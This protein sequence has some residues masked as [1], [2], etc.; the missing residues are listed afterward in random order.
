MQIE[1]ERIQM[2]PFVMHPRFFCLVLFSLVTHSVATGFT[3]AAESS[4][5]QASIV[6]SASIPQKIGRIQADKLIECS[7][8]DASV[9]DE[10][11]LWAINDGGDGPFIYALGTDGRDRGRLRIAG[12]VNR[13]WEG[14]ATF[15][16]N[17]R[18][19]ILVADF[20]DNKRQ[21]TKHT[22][23]V[24]EEPKLE[25]ERFSDNRVV[26][27]KWIVV[28]SYPDGKHD[29]EGI[30]VDTVAEKVFV[31][32]K[33]DDPP[34]LFALPLKP[35][36]GDTPVIAQKIA[37][38]ENIPPPTEVD[39]RYPYGHVRSQPTG[40]DLSGDGFSMLILT[41]KHAYLFRRHPKNSWED[42]LNRAPVLLSLP[43]PQ[44][45]RDLKQREA[46][47][48]SN[49]EASLFVTSEGR[50]AGLYRLRLKGNGQ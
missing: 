7:G 15:S 43:L 25:N 20:G 12:A 45:N 49:D 30:A 6:F 5:G 10:D 42:T 11:L 24:V 17:H 38:V 9:R 28:F 4:R 36:S 8:L 26:P 19:M 29:A 33:R 39:R 13:D 22:L 50:R 35:L 44:I 27:L 41:Y 16:W 31:L 46:I 23:Y 32:T 2:E 18:D 14:L 21:H 1:R 37:Q 48:F 40:L 47:C 3:T 34:I